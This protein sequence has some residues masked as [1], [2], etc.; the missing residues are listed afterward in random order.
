MQSDES[1]ESRRVH[2]PDRMDWRAATLLI[3]ALSLLGWLM[4]ALFA[5][6]FWR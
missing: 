6:L 5:W 4:V 3:F 1:D 2:A